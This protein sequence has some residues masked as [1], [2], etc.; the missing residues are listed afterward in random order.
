MTWRSPR[1]SMRTR[2]TALLLSLLATSWAVVPSAL[3]GHT[4]AVVNPLCL[5]PCDA[6]SP[7]PPSPAPLHDESDCPLCKA[8]GSAT[9]APQVAELAI[10]IHLT[11]LSGDSR[12]L[13]P[14][15]HHADPEAARAPPHILSV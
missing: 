15:A 11:A 1:R 2:A 14:R 12:I 10:P 5:A 7:A 3:V 8:A 6:D 13:L 4:P 9:P